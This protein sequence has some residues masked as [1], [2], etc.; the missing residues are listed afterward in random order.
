MQITQEE[1][2]MLSGGFG[3][4]TQKAME[5]LNA[6]GTI[7]E[8]DRMVPVSS[9]QISGVSFDNLGDAGLDFLAE[10][11]ADGGKVKVL[12]T[13]N[14]AGMDIE[15]WQALGIDA[16]FA[17]NQERVI[18]AYAKMG[19]VTTCSCTPYLFGN[20]PHFGE[21]IAW[22]ESSA[23]CYANSV[24]GARTN[25]EG[26]PSA[27]AAALTGFTPEYGLHLTQNRAPG[28]VFEVQAPVA[29]TARFGALGKWIGEK[30]EN[31]SPKPVPY[32]RGIESATL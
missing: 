6:L 9:V 2:K 10:M 8:A 32:L 26:G 18:E 20:L 23:V 16:D 22:A 13:L 3:R 24:L 1:Q 25:R 28:M 27:L 29:G 5:I 11:A 30:V 21:H 17:R 14:P 4:A 12:T 7:Y 19:V 31:C 15:N